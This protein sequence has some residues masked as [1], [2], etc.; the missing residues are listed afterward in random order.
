MSYNYKT[1]TFEEMVNYIETNAPEDK[2]W[3][4]SVATNEKG[5]YNHFRAK[6][7]FCQKYMPEIIPV[8]KPKK[9][10]KTDL[11]KNW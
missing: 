6:K 10:N 9:P 1:I 7:A 8:A 2:S 4:K 3:F 11:I 5:K